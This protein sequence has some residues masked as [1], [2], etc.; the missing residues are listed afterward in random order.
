MPH[1]EGNFATH[2]YLAAPKSTALSRR[3]AR[4]LRSHGA[5]VVSEHDDP[6]VTLVPLGL[7]RQ[8]F[9]E[10]FLQEVRIGNMRRRWSCGLRGSTACRLRRPVL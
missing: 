7:L 1:V 10:P 8:H 4:C 6:H 5:S 3:A 2:V 9:I